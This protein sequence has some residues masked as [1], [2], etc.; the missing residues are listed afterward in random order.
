MPRLHKTIFASLTLILLCLASAG[1]A[2]ADTFTFNTLMTPAQVEPSAQLP[3]T[4][5]T[6]SGLA[7]GT[8]DTT[9]NIIT[10]NLSFSGL[11]SPVTASHLHAPAVP[12]VGAPVVIGLAGFPLGVTSGSYANVFTLTEAQETNLLAGLFYVNIH[13]IM[14]PGGE[15]RGQI[16]LQP[17]PEL[18]TLLLLGTGLASVIGAVRRRRINLP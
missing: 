16:Q 17:V 13:T 1:I 15:I 2:Q 7:T 18:A 14:F 8:Y 9:T 11:I 6:G 10:I 4:S 3:P 5:S 12:G